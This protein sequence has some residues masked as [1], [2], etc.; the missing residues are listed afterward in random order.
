MVPTGMKSGGH[1][2]LRNSHVDGETYFEKS[3]SMAHRGVR[4]LARVKRPLPRVLRHC[5]A[6][7]QHTRGGP[8]RALRLSS[9]SSGV[10]PRTSRCL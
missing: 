7:V 2:G 4:H 8:P 1:V 10:P 6:G 5:P 3:P 9:A